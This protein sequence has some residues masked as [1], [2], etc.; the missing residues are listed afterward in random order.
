MNQTF[1]FQRWTILLAKHW[2]ENKKRYLLSVAA[3][4]SL[5]LVWF[6]FIML[7][8]DHDPLARGLQQI[9][10]YF[11]FILVGPFYASQFFSELSSKAKGTNYLMVPA[12]SLEK[13][14]SSLFYV[15]I[16]FPLVFIAA[17][18][19]VDILAVFIANA[20]HPGY[21][22]I[23]DRQGGLLKAKLVNVFYSPRPND[24]EA[25]YY[26]ILMFFA[27]QS[28]ALLGSIYFGKY[29]YIKTAISITLT[30]LVIALIGF[31]FT[32]L[33]LPRGGFNQLTN[34]RVFS[35]DGGEIK[36]IQ[37]PNWIGKALEYFFFYGFPPLFWIATYFRLKEKEV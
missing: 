35:D 10:F 13:L 36:L 3:Y 1:S 19:V 22:G 18:Y 29:S 12:S 17:F 24:R 27:L 37:L 28:A 34:Y 4:M 20:S 7:T 15:L 11:S 23:L 2:A 16:F 25:L 31:Y 5:L 21:D 14:L 8:D 32:S 6:V 30:C 9:T 33:F 26:G